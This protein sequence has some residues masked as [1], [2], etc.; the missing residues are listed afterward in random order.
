MA[1]R[2][3]ETARQQAKRILDTPHYL[4]QEI[5]DAYN[6]SIRQQRAAKLQP[7]KRRKNSPAKLAAIAKRNAG[8]KL[9]TKRNEYGRFAHKLPIQARKN[10]GSKLYTPHYLVQELK[11][12]R[13]DWKELAKFPHTPEGKKNAIEYAKAVHRVRPSSQIS[14][15]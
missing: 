8:F 2:K 13:H 6:K 9:K 7:R 15:R 3:K 12:G 11:T 1:S 14:V 10:P 5:I 4:P